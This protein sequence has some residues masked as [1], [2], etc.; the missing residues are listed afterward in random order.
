[1]GLTI[2]PF[3]ASVSAASGS[4]LNNII[5]TPSDSG[6]FVYMLN[7]AGNGSGLTM[8]YNCYHGTGLWKFDGQSTNQTSLGAWQTASGKDTYSTAG[9]PLFTDP[10]SDMS[11]QTGSSCINTGTDTGLTDDFLGNPRPVG[12]YDIGANEKQ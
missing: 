10:P 1:M 3:G 5:S 12:A 4:Y 6:Y 7:E 11:L 9:D 2:W 8:D